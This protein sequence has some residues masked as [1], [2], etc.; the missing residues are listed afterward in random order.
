MRTD[1][2]GRPYHPAKFS[3]E[4]LEKVSELIPAGS[5][6]LDPFA[7]TGLIHKIPN[8][9]SWG[10]E[11]EPE[12]AEMHA[13]TVLGDA[14][15][16]PFKDG[17][18]SYVA[19]SCTYGNRMADHHDAKDGSIR[20]TYRHSLGRPLHENNSGQ[21]HFRKGR[22]GLPYRRLHRRAWREARRVLCDGG[23]LILNISNFVRNGQIVNV[24]G[25]HKATLKKIGFELVERHKVKTRR[26]RYGA[27]GHLRTPNE[28]IYVFRKKLTDEKVSPKMQGMAKKT[29][30]LNEADLFALADAR[31]RAAAAEASA[32]K[33]KFAADQALIEQ[34]QIRN[35]SSL[36]SDKFGR[37]TRITLVEPSS[38]SING[39]TLWNDLTTSQ[40]REAFDLFLNLN[41]L[42]PNTRKAVVSLLKEMEPSALRGATKSLNVDRL[43]Q[44]VQEERIP[45]N[46]VADH[47]EEIK[48]APWVRISHGSGE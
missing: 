43:S 47:S 33:E 2:H 7:G 39:D 19:T 17:S 24:A 48:R 35:V 41:T 27:N 29:K 10:V 1:R 13:R 8:I 9:V 38:I 40:R 11:I 32:K 16:L 18:F 26:N 42:Q 20:N 36:E 31:E 44:A 3:K 37:F 5:L 22:S 21:M 14:T 4:V 12:W 23:Y 34:I 45:A 46:K 28:F 30:K 25:W 6:V 15:A